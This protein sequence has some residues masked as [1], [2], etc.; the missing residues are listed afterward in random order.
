MGRQFERMPIKPPPSRP[1]SRDW[2]CQDCEYIELSVMNRREPELT[3]VQ[4]C[5]AHRPGPSPAKL[6]LEAM[7]PWERE[8][9]EMADAIVRQRQGI[10][11]P[12]TVERGVA[13]TALG[14]AIKT[15][16]QMAL[17]VAMMVL[18]GWYEELGWH[19]IFWSALVAIISFIKRISEH[20][21]NPS[22]P[23]DD[24]FAVPRSAGRSRQ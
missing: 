8:L 7:E 4:H 14:I 5:K 19:L 15:F 10:V 18:A 1:S 12:R 21:R 20:A 23:I 13:L 2:L 16:T 3:V 24:G 11:V 22:A 9:E 6:R 17:V